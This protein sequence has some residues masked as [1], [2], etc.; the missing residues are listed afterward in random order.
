MR[1]YHVLLL[2]PISQTHIDFLDLSISQNFWRS[3]HVRVVFETQKYTN[4]QREPLP[5][6]RVNL[7]T[8]LQEGL[9]PLYVRR[10]TRTM[11][12]ERERVNIF[13]QTSC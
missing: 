11:G 13:W 1:F 9:A 5:I 3:H 8:Y 10:F 7:R 12:S 6:V 2:L 4:T